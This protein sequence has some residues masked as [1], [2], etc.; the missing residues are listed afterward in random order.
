MGKSIPQWDNY[1]IR[2][3]KK[4]NLEFSILWNKTN[5]S[6][7]RELQRTMNADKAKKATA[8]ATGAKKPGTQ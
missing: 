4:A 1:S 7:A 8:A 3:T 6:I 2:T 5:A